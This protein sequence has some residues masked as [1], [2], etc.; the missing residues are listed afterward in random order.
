METVNRNHFTD[1]LFLLIA[2]LLVSAVLVLQPFSVHVNP[3]VP[4]VAANPLAACISRANEGNW[5]VSMFD[6]AAYDS[7]RAYFPYDNSAVSQPELIPVS[8]VAP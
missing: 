5:S 2:V 6:G 4:A 1:A 8:P 7:C 3:V